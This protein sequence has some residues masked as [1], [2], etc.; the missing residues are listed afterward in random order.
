MTVDRLWYLADEASQQAEQA[1][2]RLTARHDATL[3]PDYERRVSRR[4]FRT[5][6]ER[7]RETGAPYGAHTVVYRDSGE[8]LLVRHEGVDLWVLPGGEVDPGETFREAAERELA[9]EAGVEVAYDGL[10]M[11]GRVEVSSGDHETWGV[12]PVFAAEAVTTEP[13]VADP[14]GEISEAR[15]FD[16]LPEDTRDREDLVAWRERVLS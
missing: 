7:I 1:Y 9:E 2:H 15:W 14:D 3:E 16:D 6:A 5:L 8:L 11:L 4:R 12:L 13:E 10:G